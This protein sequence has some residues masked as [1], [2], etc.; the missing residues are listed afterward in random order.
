MDD[1]GV[2]PLR[3]AGDAKFA[4]RRPDGSA[5]LGFD[6]PDFGSV[7]TVPS[8][9]VHG[10]GGVGSW[11][12]GVRSFQHSASTP[13]VGDSIAGAV[14]SFVAPSGLLSSVASGRQMSGTC[15]APNVAQRLPQHMVDVPHGAPMP[16]IAGMHAG[17]SYAAGVSPFSCSSSSNRASS[18]PWRTSSPASR[19][20]EPV[21][22]SCGARGCESH[23]FAPNSNP[24]HAASP[25]GAN[26][27]TGACPL[28]PSAGIAAASPRMHATDTAAFSFVHG[29]ACP[30]QHPHQPPQRSHQEQFHSQASVPHQ[31]QSSPQPHQTWPQQSQ[32]LPSP[33]SYMWPP[34]PSQHHSS[35]TPSNSVPP[36]TGHQY[37]SH[38]DVHSPFAGSADN[39]SSGVG[40]KKVRNAPLCEGHNRR[41]PTA[42]ASGRSHGVSG[43]AVADSSRIKQAHTDALNDGFQVGPIACGDRTSLKQ[44][45]TSVS[46]NTLVG[47]GGWGLCFGDQD[48]ANT[49]WALTSLLQFESHVSP[50]SYPLFLFGVSLF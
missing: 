12:E 24:Q 3:P 32:H 11:P 33:Q 47:G 15:P 2:F 48:V 45:V 18:A 25:S 10:G 39:R 34:L 37:F 20:H 9:T 27:A 41:T 49:R 4:Q 6:M 1:D 40:A 36:H 28:N 35:H 21:P 26:G 8:H 31:Q 50:S 5:M 13:R 23:S 19:T 16:H 7:G 14:S 46:S 38:A 42:I 22:H 43:G 30:T 29:C 44:L 17:Q